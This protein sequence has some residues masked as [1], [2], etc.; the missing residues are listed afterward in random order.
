M[1]T[2]PCD[3]LSEC[4]GFLDYGVLAV[5]VY[6]YVVIEDLP[7]NSFVRISTNDYVDRFQGIE[8]NNPVWKSM[9]MVSIVE[10]NT[11]IWNPGT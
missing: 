4:V 7:D 8:I 6:Q 11:K 10:H 5:N 9:H 1:N 2:P 3:P